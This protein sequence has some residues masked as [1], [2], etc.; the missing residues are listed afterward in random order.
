MR[1]IVIGVTG[2][3]FLAISLGCMSLSFGGRTEVV[4]PEGALTRQSDTIH[5]GPA[6]EIFVY[7]PVPYAT[8]PNLV[9]SDTWRDCRVVEQR[10][11]GFRVKN[12]S[13]SA[14][15]MDWTARGTKA[16]AAAVVVTSPPSQPTEPTASAPQAR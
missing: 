9:V 12:M 4:A 3:L 8:P 2:L 11:D 16:L 10:P 14:R 1:H 15:D 7:Y 6:Q 5:L 13:S